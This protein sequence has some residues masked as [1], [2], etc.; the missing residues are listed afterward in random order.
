M[1]DFPIK[2]KIILCSIAIFVLMTLTCVNAAQ[3]GDD[4]GNVTEITDTKNFDFTD[5]AEDINVSSDENTVL[6]TKNYTF[7]SQRDDKYADGIDITTDNLVIDGQGHTINADKKAR[8]FNINSNNVVLRNIALINANANSHGGAIQWNGLNGTVSGSVFENCS[9]PN[10]GGAVMFKNAVTVENSRFIANTAYFGGGVNFDSGSTVSNCEFR[11]NFATFL[12]GG[13]YSLDEINVFNSTFA[14]NEAGD[15]GGIYLESRGLIENVTFERNNAIGYGGGI[16]NEDEITIRNSK[17]I[18][19]T[20]KYAGALF[21]KGNGNVA[22]STFDENFADIGGAIYVNCYVCNIMDTAFRYNNAPKG[23]SLY[24]TAKKIKIIN[25]SFTN[26][27]S[28]YESE[29]CMDCNDVK[30]VNLTYYNVTQPKKED[31]IIINDTGNNNTNPV[32]PEKNTDKVTPK[33][34][35]K[36]STRITAKSRAFSKKAKTKMYRVALK[37]GKIILKYKIVFIKVKGKTYSA[38]TN[39]K[40]HA[41]FKIRLSIKGKFKA[42]ITFKGD[43]SY[44]PSKKT[45][46]IKIK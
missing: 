31:E 29:I 23:I 22:N 34:I 17:F 33:K 10:S 39:N 4:S 40:G 6:L 45:V 25:V 7:N 30:L 20:G 9:S 18:R 36:K 21:F 38:K 12:G 13:I 11:D 46:Y 28:G 2:S 14:E 37:S 8:I 15:G 26:N 32:I 41:T 43:K 5:L 35:T 1:G 3:I 27:Q 42:I 19:N 16:T 24:V 44:K